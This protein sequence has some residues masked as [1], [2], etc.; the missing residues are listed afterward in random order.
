MVPTVTLTYSAITALLAVIVS[1]IFEYA[2]VLHDKY[3]ALPDNSQ[4]LVM[5]VALVVLVLVIFGLGCIGWVAGT[6]C[7]LAGAQ[8]MIWMLLSGIVANQGVFPILPKVAAA[9]KPATKP[10]GRTLDPTPPTAQ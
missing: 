3:N 2:P 7:T 6:V 4:R 5:L 8:T 9:P 10:L 1:V